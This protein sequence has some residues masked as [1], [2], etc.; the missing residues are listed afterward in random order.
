MASI[1]VKFKKDDKPEALSRMI[2]QYIA[3]MQ[4]PKE[5]GGKDLEEPKKIDK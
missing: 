5:V 2:D 4:D 3:W 1:K